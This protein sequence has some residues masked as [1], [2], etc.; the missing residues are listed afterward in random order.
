VL[1]PTERFSNRVENYIKYR[2]QY[3]PVILDLLKTKM[4]LR[5][6]S[7]VADTGSGTGLLSQLLLASGCIVYGVEPNQAMREAGERL[8]QAYPQFRSI[9]G[10]AEATT[11]ESSSVDFITAGQA[12]HWFDIDA[13]RSEFQ[14]ILRPAGWVVI[15][16][17]SRRKDSAPFLEAYDKLLD[18]F[19]T[20]YRQVSHLS[21]GEK[22]LPRFFKGQ[23]SLEVFDNYQALDY[24]SLK[25]RLLSSSYA[26]LEGH[27]RYEAMIDELKR[28]FD[29]YQRDG[30]VRFEYDTEVY[31]GHIQA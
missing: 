24:E 19:G 14:R 31:Y 15:I 6:S 17:N 27:P 2:P 26:P 28:I 3:P 30:Q 16:W 12:F 23:F 4:G 29:E 18:D 10:T 21:V 20:D 25:G 7:V 8:L 9:N 11:L 13:A 1:A 5:P 22:A